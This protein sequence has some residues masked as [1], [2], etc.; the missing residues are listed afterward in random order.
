LVRVADLVQVPVVNAAVAEQYSEGC[1]ATWEPRLGALIA[2]ITGSARPVDKDNITEDE[3]AVI[4]G[5]RPD[6]K[7]ALIRHVEGKRNDPPSSEAVEMMAMDE[8][9]PKLELKLDSQHGET[10]FQVP[11]A[12]SKL[13]GHRGVATF[14]PDREFARQTRPITTILSPARQARSAS[15]RPFRQ[16]ETANRQTRGKWLLQYYLVTR[17]DR[18]GNRIRLFHSIWEYRMPVIFDRRPS[19]GSGTYEL[20]TM[21]ATPA[22]QGKRICC[23]HHDH[24]RLSG[25]FSLMLFSVRD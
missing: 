20:E 5:V 6:G 17:G 23:A 4:V 18:S 8:P 3:L 11:V 9:L 7:G 2:T 19:T 25:I 21:G 13:H 10:A 14:H 24:R 1:F 12:R 22:R 16:P 15:A